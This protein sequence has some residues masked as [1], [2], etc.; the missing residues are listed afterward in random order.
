MK[1]KTKRLESEFLLVASACRAVVRELDAWLRL[2]GWEGVTV[3]HAR[4]TEGQMAMIYGRDWKR[5]GLWSWH[6]T[7]HA[8]DIRNRVWTPSQR[9]DIVKFLRKNWPEAEVLMHD[10]GRGDHLHI[11]IPPPRSRWRRL[12]RW[13]TRRRKA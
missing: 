9:K 3:T 1:F 12:K 8:V 7:G 6:L 2:K 10:I 11:A 5:R 4:R 13:F